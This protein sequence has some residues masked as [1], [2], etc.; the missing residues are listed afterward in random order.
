MTAD[1]LVFGIFC[2]HAASQRYFS[3]TVNL[4]FFRIFRDCRPVSFCRFSLNLS[5]LQVFAAFCWP[6]T[7]KFLQF[8]TDHWP[9]SFCRFSL[10]AD[11]QI[12]AIF[13]WLQTCECLAFFQKCW[14]KHFRH[15][16]VIVVLQFFGSFPFVIEFCHFFVTVHLLVFGFFS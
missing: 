1:H 5:D 13:W 14:P 2:H 3:I 12:L 10:T 7:C 16:S 11:L 8:F 9:A 6:Q 4:W 15:F